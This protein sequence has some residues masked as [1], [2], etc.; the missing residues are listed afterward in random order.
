MSEHHTFFN[1]IT[2]PEGN[3]EEA[4]AAWVAIGEYMETQKGFIGSTLF[5]NRRDPKMLINQGWYTTQEDFMA[6][7]QSEQFQALSQK[8]TDLGVERIA[9]LY[10]EVRSFGKK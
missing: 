1:V 10:D 3:D 6:S 2:F 4:F 5:R 7:V 9:G 8:L